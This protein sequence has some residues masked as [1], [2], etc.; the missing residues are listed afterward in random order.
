M[1][2]L[3][4]ARG[5]TKRFGGLTALNAVDFELEE[6]RIASIIGP[7]G[8][9]KTT[10]FTVFTALYVAPAPA[11]ASFSTP[12][13]TL[14]LFTLLEVTSQQPEP[15]PFALRASGSGAVNTTLEPF[16]ETAP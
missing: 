1:A 14:G 13:Y 3:L 5:V 7:D 16:S 4:E 8:A 9:G 10:F 15:A 2:T 6:G 11:R 12:T